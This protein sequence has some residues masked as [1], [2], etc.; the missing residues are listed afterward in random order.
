MSLG[1]A[2]R[3]LKNSKEKPCYA[4]IT[5]IKTPFLPMTGIALGTKRHYCLTGE[6][7]WMFPNVKMGNFTRSSLVAQWV[8]DPALSVQQLGSLLWLGFDPWPGKEE[9]KVPLE[10]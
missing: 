3:G 10:F 1:V 9:K 7:L 8:K 6:D 5:L 4:F 2:E